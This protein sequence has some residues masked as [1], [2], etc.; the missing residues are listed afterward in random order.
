MPVHPCADEGE[1]LAK[2]GYSSERC[3]S[4]DL[5]WSDGVDVAFVQVVCV[6]DARPLVP[7]LHAR[8][9]DGEIAAFVAVLDRAVVETRPCAP[10]E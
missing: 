9:G 7:G 1:L 3:T 5:W 2:L 10:L 8:R 6:G 4:V